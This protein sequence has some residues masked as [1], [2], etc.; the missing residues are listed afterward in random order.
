MTVGQP[1]GLAYCIDA[2]GD[3]QKKIFEQFTQQ[4]MS[5]PQIGAC[6]NTLQVQPS[7]FNDN[8]LHQN[9]SPHKHSTLRGGNVPTIHQDS[10][11][12]MQLRRMSCDAD[13]A[14]IYQKIQLGEH[15]S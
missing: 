1:A 6:R 13:Y 14:A 5:R 8:W 9:T 11:T 2:V 15:C 3:M 12:I 4:K 10:A 7:E